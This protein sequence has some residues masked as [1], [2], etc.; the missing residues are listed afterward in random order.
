M[1]LTA[2]RDVV[3][4]NDKVTVH[5]AHTRPLPDRKRQLV[6]EILM[7]IAAAVLTLCRCWQRGEGL[8]TLISPYTDNTNGYRWHGESN[9]LLSLPD[10][11]TP[12]P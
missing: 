2:D 3:G 8:V 12:W 4:H 11:I 10:S 5:Y 6:I 9:E 1:L 7:R